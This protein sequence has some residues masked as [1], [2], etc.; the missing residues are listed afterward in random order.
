[1]KRTF[2]A[3]AGITMIL[4]LTACGGGGSSPPPTSPPPTYVTHILSDPA[5]DGYIE[6]TAPTTLSIVQGMSPTVQSLF[7]G[8]DPVTL[9]ETRAFLDFPVRGSGGVPLG[10]TINSATLE[11]TINGIRPASGVI[12]IRI[13]LVAFQ[14]PDLIATDFDRTIQPALAF[15]TVSPPISSA[16]VNGN[17]SV[18]VTPLMAKAQYLGLVDFQLR[19]MEDLGIVSPG[20]IEIDDSIGPDRGTVAPLLTVTYQ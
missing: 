16:D 11:F 19:I 1:M 17:V 8:V 15:T 13:E 10:A 6:E 18:D 20:E 14:P 2:F 3:I 5:F 4:S 9:L 12:P 7:A